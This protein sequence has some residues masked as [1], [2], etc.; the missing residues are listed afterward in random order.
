M[1]KRKLKNLLIGVIVL[2]MVMTSLQSS[3]WAGDNKADYSTESSLRDNTGIQDIRSY[4][5]RAGENNKNHS[6]ACISNKI[7]QC[8]QYKN[9][10]TFPSNT[11]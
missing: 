8:G 6:E 7:E 10:R 5:V 3:A 9:Q 4:F 11:L 2:G 1:G